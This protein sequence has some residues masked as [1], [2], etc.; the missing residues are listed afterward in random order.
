SASLPHG[1]SSSHAH[2]DALPSSSVPAVPGLG[3]KVAASAP[4]HIPV[5]EYSGPPA[6]HSSSP[7]LS[8]VPPA[9]VAQLEELHNSKLE[10]QEPETSA[11]SVDPNSDDDNDTALEQHH[12]RKES[13]PIT[14]RRPRG[15]N[16]YKLTRRGS[17]SSLYSITTIDRIAKVEP[18]GNSLSSQDSISSSFGYHDGDDSDDYATR[19]RPSRIDEM[20]QDPGI[21]DAL[22]VMPGVPFND[23][24]PL[25]SDLPPV[26]PVRLGRTAVLLSP[27]AVTAPGSSPLADEDPAV[28]PSQ[29]L[30]RR[31]ASRGHDL[32]LETYAA[33][34]SE[35]A[36]LMDADA[37]DVPAL[38]PTVREDVA[39][40]LTHIETAATAA[41]A[42]AAPEPDAEKPV[43][44]VEDVLVE[45]W[46]P[47]AAIPADDSTPV[48][49]SYTSEEHEITFGAAPTASAPATDPS[50]QQDD[51]SPAG[52]AVDTKTQ[53]PT[54]APSTAASTAPM[55]HGS[56]GSTSSGD[57]RRLVVSQLRK[58]S[59][60]DRRSGRAEVIHVSVVMTPQAA[61]ATD[62]ETEVPEDAVSAAPSATSADDADAGVAPDAAAPA[63]PAA[64]AADTAAAA[65]AA[66]AA[67]EDD[68]G[69]VAAR[70]R[71]PTLKRR[72]T[73][74]VEAS[75]NV[76]VAAL[77]PAPAMAP[78][79]SKGGTLAKFFQFIR[80]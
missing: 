60:L 34:V 44:I 18:R 41:D 61:F 20:M 27:P 2:K 25:V 43:Y 78:S 80:S 12:E 55:R 46:V 42:A 1:A 59:T 14:L 54:P 28:P 10:S 32:L 9:S 57:T 68:A 77:P 76:P 21:V 7:R 8:V 53:N 23:S 48:V 39:T 72:T 29:I 15:N 22:R 11:A 74:R 70:P 19:P 5:L 3:A 64:A 67:I 17:F 4:T 71:P 58:V 37:A 6:V 24:E 75:Q 36:D 56:R 35:I 52:A 63:P 50:P 13:M 79:P 40:A 26:L 47:T 65:D 16:K 62:D 66:P 33:I 69:A 49:L 51:S 73:I 38:A 30:S 45:H 31:R